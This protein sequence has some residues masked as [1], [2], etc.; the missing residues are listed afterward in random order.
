[1]ARRVS[2]ATVGGAV[3]T[4]DAVSLRSGWEQ[5][6]EVWRADAVIAEQTS[7]RLEEIGTRFVARL[8]RSGLASWE[9]VQQG[10]CRSFVSAPTRSGRPPSPAT[11]HL[12]RSTVRAIFRTLRSI[13]ATAGDPTLDLVLPPRQARAYRPLTDDEVL[14]C[15]ATSRLGESGAASLRRAVAWALGEATAATGEIG[16]VRLEHLDSPDKP[17][18]VGFPASRRYAARSGRLTDWGARVIARQAGA[19]V[20]AGASG[21]TLLAYGG[22]GAG[23]QYLAQASVCTQLTKILEVAGLRDDPGVQARSL[24]GWAGRRLYAAGVPLE[25]VAVRLGCH[26]LDAAAAEIGLQWKPSTP[27]S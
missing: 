5:V 26:S 11:Q 12:R 14:L 17:R 7:D 16:A 4:A 9:D 10:H 25:Q 3:G 24:R 15:R 23:G 21:S 13:G 22:T 1:M 8:S 6:L 2:A 18:W 20:V 19:L 27:P